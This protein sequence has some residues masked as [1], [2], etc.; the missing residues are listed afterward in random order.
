MQC[1]LLRLFKYHARRAFLNLLPAEI[2]CCGFQFLVLIFF[3]AGCSTP[4][5]GL[6][7]QYPPFEKSTFSRWGNFVEVDS[8]QPTLRWQPF[9][10][11]QDRAVTTAGMLTQIEGITYELRI[12]KTKATRCMRA[13][14]SNCL[15]TN[16]RNRWSLRPGISGASG[17]IFYW[18]AIL[19]PSNGGLRVVWFVKKRFQIRPAIDLSRF[20]YPCEEEYLFQIKM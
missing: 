5:A 3:L 15:T 11:P 10:R 1:T 7:P 17:L 20:N 6:Q 16:W 14:A 9:P 2:C 12:W 13:T 18:M 4:M 8:L 19:A